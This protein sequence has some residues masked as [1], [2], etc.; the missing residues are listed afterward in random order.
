M[1]F[2]ILDVGHGFCA[3]LRH[4]NGNVMLFD[5]GHKTDPEFRPSIYL[6]NQGIH[7]IERLF[8]TNYDEDHISDLPRL[9][10]RLSIS[11]LRRNK[12]IS[13]SQLRELKRQSGPISDAMSSLLEMSDGYTSPVTD[14]PDFP[15]VTFTTYHNDYPVFRDTNNLSLVVFL[16]C[17]GTKFLM[18][19]DLETA[20]WR[21]L[22][23]NAAFR[24]EL[25]GVHVFV[26]SHH[27]R[28]NGYCRELF[29]P[30][31]PDVIIFSDSNIRHAT[32]QMAN[33]YAQHASGHHLQRAASPGSEHPE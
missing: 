13:V 31:H 15:R 2:E 5:C 17:N 23:A 10:A 27:G 6:P 12:S 28:E 22:L 21:A 24:T 32:Q 18:P 29:D 11:I 9:R 3:W 30:C 1:R 8:V 26:A 20:G 33:T 16:T 14:P 19:G 7:R 4:D 25:A